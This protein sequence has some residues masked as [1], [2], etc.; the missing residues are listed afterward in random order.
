MSQNINIKIL[1]SDKTAKA[2]SGV[3]KRFASLAA[4]G[5]KVG[6]ALGA[7]FV[8]AGAALTALTV[9]SMRSIDALAKQADKIGITTEALAGMQFAGEQT[10]VATETM[11]MALQRFTRR[12]SEAAMGTGEAKAAIKELGINASVL[13]RMPLDKQMEVIADSMNGLSTQADKV[14]IAMKLFDS[15]G[16]S[17]V[18]TLRGGSQGLREMTAEADAL[19]LTLSRADAAKIEMANDAINKMKKS[20]EGFGNQLA[21]SL[22]P[23]ITQIVEDFVSAGKAS[24]EFGS[25]GEKAADMLVTGYAKMQDGLHSANVMMSTA[26]LT[27]AEWGQSF[28]KVLTKIVEL[29]SPIEKLFEAYNS[30]IGLFGG[31]AVKLPS[32]F[33]QEV[34]KEYADHVEG[35][36]TKLDELLAQPL[37][38]EGI[39]AY[40]D[41][42][43]LASD[44]A[45]AAIIANQEKIAERTAFYQEIQVTAQRKLQEVTVTAVRKTSAKENDTRLENAAR[46]K[47]DLE[48]GL[49][50]LARVNKKAFAIQKAYNIG[51]TIMNTYAAAQKAVFELGP[52]AGPFAAALIVAGGL[53]NIAQIKAQSFEGGGFT[54]FGVRAGGVDGKGGMPAIVHPNETIID[55]TL[56]DGQGQGMGATVNF[57][58]QAHD[59]SGFDQLLNSRRG[60]IMAMIDDVLNDQGRKFA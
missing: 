51:Q 35:L 58:I 48:G 12:V 54:G 7:A 30:V 10:G 34:G 47:D 22:S 18:N 44:E 6:A 19:G 37:P 9:S 41:A 4:V 46:R 8:A 39:F 43:I 1:A 21:V 36:K 60:D 45:T 40:R 38:S 25:S 11:N 56:D 3:K 13:A 14:R 15:E 53:A 59:A 31:D 26:K 28:Q 57:N 29:F 32:Q 23:L 24:D 17:L 16:V 27:T 50:S 5:K 33:M 20:A 2:F 42:A 52:I 55:H 49:A